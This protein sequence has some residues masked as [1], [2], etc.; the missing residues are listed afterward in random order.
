M[1]RPALTLLLSLSLALAA[2]VAGAAEP[3]VRTYTVQPGD[4]VW[5]IAEAFYGKGSDYR[6]IYQYNKFVGR[7]PYLLK[8]GQ[9]LRLPVGTMLPEA[10]VSWLKREVQA[11]PPRS[12]DWLEAHEKMNLWKLYKVATGDESAA[13]IVFE[14][15]SDLRLRDNALLVIYSGSAARAATAA[16]RKEKT[17]VVLEHG[18]IRGGLAQLD[19]ASQPMVVETPSGVVDLLA[20]VVQIEAQARVSAVSVYDGKAAVKAQGAKVDVPEGY[21]TVVEKGQKPRPPKPLPPAPAWATDGLAE[22]VLAAPRG[23][24]AS[25]KAAWKPLADVARYRVELARDQAFTQVFIDVEVD[26]QIQQAFLLKDVG[27]G[28]YWAR[29]AGITAERLE[30]APSAPL[31]VTVLQVSSARRL[32]PGADG[33][34]E[35][36][37]YTKLDGD[38]DADGLEWA[39]DDHAFASAKDDL[40]IMTPGE[41]RVRFR[42][43]GAAQ[44][45]DGLTVRVIPVTGAIEPPPPPSLP[46]EAPREIAVELVDARGNPAALP[47]LR[48]T[49]P[50]DAAEIP[51]TP[52]AP[53]RWTARFAPPASAAGPS[54]PLVLSWAGGELATARLGVAVA[55]PE[56]VP[57]PPAD[58][59][60]LTADVAPAW[61]RRADVTPAPAMEM[62]TH[63]GV[64]GRVIDQGAVT[65]LGVALT[66]ELALAGDRLGLDAD[67]T[68]LRPQLTSDTSA[69]DG[70]VGDLVVGARYRLLGDDAFDVAPSLRLRA[71]LG[72]RVSE[73]RL[74]GV[75]PGVLLGA[76]LAGG[77]LAL[78][79]RQAA[80]VA[81]AFEADDLH[82]SYG[83][84]YTVVARLAGFLALS[85]GL[86]TTL[87]LVRPDGVAK[88]D[89][90]GLGVAGGV[91][92]FVDRVRVGLVVGAGL[93][94]AAREATGELSGALTLDLGYGDAAV[95]D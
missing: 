65:T 39:L 82:V 84:S 92:L 55:A 60:W 77:A 5:S 89:G 64:H 16:R 47:G 46:G 57:E 78:E 6:I 23:S 72:K 69:R 48:L 50:P 1:R 8:P 76:T 70:G 75:E 21:G 51:L 79:T 32:E 42:R 90:L 35:V 22:V 18:T 58:Y 12:I 9:V 2:P 52:T 33:A 83:G 91:Y 93:N 56:P 10:Q 4:S 95:G 14:D 87:A 61:D 31:A 13:H 38:P 49:A 59:R 94:D 66:G 28:T 26:A 20:R 62:V 81:T 3:D 25:Y 24:L 37:G 29:V 27:P 30:G 63:V 45:G 15:E 36:V 74:A 53:G 41:H 43:V 54:V 7:P 71:P 86:D 68:F 19:A 80:I 44:Q 73:P 17:R 40:V 34:F 88:P 11:K 85:A 67:L